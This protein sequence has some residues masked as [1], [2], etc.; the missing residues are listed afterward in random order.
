[1]LKDITNYEGIYLTCGVTDLRR[2][3]G[4]F[5]G[6]KFIWLDLYLF[7]VTSY[8]AN[9]SIISALI[10]PSTAGRIFFRVSLNL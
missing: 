4:R 3:A 7:K 1:M 5:I 10:N 8:D 2:S 6:G 9:S